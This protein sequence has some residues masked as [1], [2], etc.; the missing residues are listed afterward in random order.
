M[1]LEDALSLFHCPAIGRRGDNEE[2]IGIFQH[3][4]FQTEFD[5][6]G[7]DFLSG[8]VQ[9]VFPSEL[10]RKK[11]GISFR[12][13]RPELRSVE[14]ETQKRRR[15]QIRPPDPPFQRF[16][17]PFDPAQRFRKLLFP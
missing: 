10:L 13:L 6:L 1:G 2:K 8:G 7:H 15:F 3:Q 14:E 4:P 11:G 12:S 16:D 9:N 17:F 5:P